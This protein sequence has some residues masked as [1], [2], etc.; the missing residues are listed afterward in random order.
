M[1]KLFYKTFITQILPCY[2][3]LQEEKSCPLFSSMPR[4]YF[5]KLSN[6]TETIVMEN[7]R[8]QGYVVHDKSIPL[9]LD[10]L[11][12]V[13]KAYAEWHA[14]SFALKD[15]KPQEYAELTKNLQE[16]PFK[17]FFRTMFGTLLDHTLEHLYVMLEEKGEV[18]LLHKYKNALGNAKG[19]IVLEKLLDEPEEVSVVLHGDCWNN[20][21]MFK[22]E[23]S[24][25][26]IQTFN[27]TELMY[28]AGG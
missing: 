17:N 21:L 3:K 8:P 2:H 28:Q 4:C 6:P 13:L 12:V 9:D 7:L 19:S 11:H 5:A 24:L 15:Q 10:H 20:N 27:F 1:K 22:Y 16:S 14:L 18:E 25:G 26:L 23:V